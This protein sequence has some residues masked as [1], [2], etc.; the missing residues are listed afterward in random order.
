MEE[1]VTQE[2]GGKPLLCV[3]VSMYVDMWQM[4]MPVCAY[5]YV[6]FT[7]ACV[8]VCVRE[9]ESEKWHAYVC[10]HASHLLRKH[11]APLRH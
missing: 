5:A 3:C 11:L 4:S 2:T 1:D 7:C 8:S 6:M 10:V 9:R